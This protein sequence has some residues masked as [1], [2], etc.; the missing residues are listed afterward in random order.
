MLFVTDQ[1]KVVS[2]FRMIHFH[3]SLK[4][5]FRLIKLPQIQVDRPQI[6]VCLRISRLAGNRILVQGDGV[7]IAFDMTQAIGQ[8]EV[9]KR[10]TLR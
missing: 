8:T 3:S 2:R 4:S 9:K 7:V 5:L 6:V 10:Y 1:S